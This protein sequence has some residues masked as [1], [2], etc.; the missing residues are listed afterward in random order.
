LNYYFR[1]MQHNDID[2]VWSLIELLKH[3]KVDMSFTEITVK[4]ELMDFV[5]NPAQLT[6][7]AVSKDEPSHV[8]CLVK[9]RRDLAKAK[10]HAAFLSAATHPDA[11]GLGLVAKL[12]NY[13]L[14]EM[15]KEGVTIARIYVY[16]DNLASLSA[17]KKLGF[18]HSGTVL[19]HHMDFSTGE[20]VH[21]LIFHKILDE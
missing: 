15:K 20:Y 3:E 16:S 8:L 13:A 11:R 12:T 6:Y 19:K 5:D 18:N 7:V 2:H 9:G 10:S 1:K 4:D 17:V 21:D 14:D